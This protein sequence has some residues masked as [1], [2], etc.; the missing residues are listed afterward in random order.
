MRLTQEFIDEWADLEEYIHGMAKDKGF[1]EEDDDLDL[2]THIVIAQKLCL[3]HSEISEALEGA[4]GSGYGDLGAS[5]DKIP[6]YSSVEEELADA[7]IRVF[8]LAGRLDLDIIG[9]ISAKL[10]YNFNRPYKHGKTM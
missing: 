1:W 4:R 8:D 3:V 5:S 10:D 6:E 2:P 7:I 9:A